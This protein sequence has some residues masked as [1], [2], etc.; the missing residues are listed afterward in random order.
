[1]YVLA[2]KQKLAGSAAEITGTGILDRERK[3]IAAARAFF[4]AG[5]DK[6]R[7][8]RASHPEAAVNRVAACIHGNA[9]F[10]LSAVGYA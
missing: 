8:A 5:Y 9:V 7:G 4:F 1:M 6:L 3:L 2:G 10:H